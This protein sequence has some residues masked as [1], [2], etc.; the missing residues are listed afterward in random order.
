MKKSFKLILTLTAGALLLWSCGTTEKKEEPEPTP[1][2]V[3][4]YDKLSD[5]LSTASAQSKTV[6]KKLDIFVTYKYESLAFIEDK[7]AGAIIRCENHGL[8]SGYEFTGDITVTYQL[9]DYDPDYKGEKKEV[10]ITKIDVSKAVKTNKSVELQNSKLN[11]AVADFKNCSGKKMRF[12]DTNIVLGLDGETIGEEGIIAQ[13]SDY[14][15]LVS[16]GNKVTKIETGKTGDV[17]G[18]LAYLDGE[19]SMLIFGTSNFVERELPAEESAFTAL[20]TIGIY[21]IA[22]EKTPKG[23]LT[24]GNKVQYSARTNGNEHIYHI[25]S[26][27]ANNDASLKFTTSKISCG[28]LYFADSYVFQPIGSFTGGSINVVCAKKTDDLLWLNDNTNDIG[29][30][31]PNK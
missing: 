27:P 26:I 25:S 22:D 9:G 21:N 15:N 30:I 19:Q 6:T 10:I 4:V 13:G 14:I 29:F 11:E 2:P 8:N 17:I 18:Y 1:E 5:I 12:K 7:S 24:S 16:Q 20:T 23:L 28:A 31:V 3:V